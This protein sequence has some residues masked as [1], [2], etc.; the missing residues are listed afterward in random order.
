MSTDPLAVLLDWVAE[1]TQAGDPE[2]DAMTLATAT[3]D[4]RPSARVV[5]FRGITEGRIRFFTN[6]S[7][8]KGGELEANPYAALVFFWARTGRQIRVE[9]PTAHLSPAESDA[10]FAAR[11]RGHRLQALASPQSQPIASLDELRDRHQQAE[12][13]HE[14]RE[15]PRPA[16]WGGYGLTPERIE[17]WV[18]GADRLHDRRLFERDGAGW[19]EQR[20]AP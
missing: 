20:L 5:L 4:G 2:P 7:S 19:R 13:E 16:Y 10:Y 15:V 18:K 14:G 6:Y 9:G 1:A 3:P 11:P 17:L 12:A 8:R